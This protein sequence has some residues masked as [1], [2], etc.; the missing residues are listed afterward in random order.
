[1]K[2]NFSFWFI[3]TM[4]MDGALIVTGDMRF[5][6]PILFCL[7]MQLFQLLLLHNRIALRK[8]EEATKKY[9]H[10]EDE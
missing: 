3:G 6:W 2:Y 7:T 1:M 9:K 8:H 4:I 10:E 5:W